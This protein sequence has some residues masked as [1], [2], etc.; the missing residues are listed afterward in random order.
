MYA[1][2]END[3]KTTEGIQHSGCSLCVSSGTECSHLVTAE[4]RLQMAKSELSSEDSSGSYGENDLIS[5]SYE[6]SKD[7]A[8]VRMISDNCVIHCEAD[9]TG[10]CNNTLA[11]L[12]DHISICNNN[13][14]NRTDNTSVCNNALANLTDNIGIIQCNNTPANLTGFDSTLCQENEISR[15]KIPP[16]LNS[17]STKNRLGSKTARV[18]QAN[19]EL[20]DCGVSFTEADQFSVGSLYSV[21]GIDGKLTLEYDW[22]QSLKEDTAAGSRMTNMLRRLVHLAVME[23]TDFRLKQKQ[24]MVSI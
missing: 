18:L 13:L 21:M 15:N 16:C 2:A 5:S 3:N 10:V 8:E 11:N 14:T 7:N 23:L 12:T 24:H 19:L 6:G 9:N 1:V 4:I 20:L 17:I 22:Q